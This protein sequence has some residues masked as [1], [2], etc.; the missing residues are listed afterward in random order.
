MVEERSGDARSSPWP[1]ELGGQQRGGNGLLWSEGEGEWYRCLPHRQGY[2]GGCRDQTSWAWELGRQ[3]V[4]FEGEG[5][6]HML[7]RPLSV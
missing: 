4:V 6:S 2:S 7:G 5:G 1:M 3:Q